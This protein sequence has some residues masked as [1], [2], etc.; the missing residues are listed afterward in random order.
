MAW[1]TTEQLQMEMDSHALQGAGWGW[2]SGA[3]LPSL[4]AWL[5]RG[6]DAEQATADAVFEAFQ[7]LLPPA[8]AGRQHQVSS[9]EVGSKQGLAAGM[10]SPFSSP[11]CTLHP[12]CPELH[13]MSGSCL[14]CRP[15]YAFV[16]GC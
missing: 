2:Y 9:L 11:L 7:D 15:A 8:L 10:Q 6:S 4:I 12:K 13:S 16:A 1:L 14:I 5:E 3:Q